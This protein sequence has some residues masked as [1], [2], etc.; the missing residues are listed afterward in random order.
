LSARNRLICFP[1][2]RPKPAKRSRA[3]EARRERIF[4]LQKPGKRRASARIQACW[5]ARNRSRNRQEKGALSGHFEQT[6]ECKDLAFKNVVK[7]LRKTGW[8]I[9]P[10]RAIYNDKVVAYEKPARETLF[11]SKKA[12]VSKIISYLASL[13]TAL[14]PLSAIEI[15][16]CVHDKYCYLGEKVLEKILLLIVK[17]F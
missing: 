6:N 13:W 14:K 11:P 4:P 9:R 10:K 2:E 15:W 1:K 5:R 3:Q 8:P 7:S 17:L 12:I 16:S